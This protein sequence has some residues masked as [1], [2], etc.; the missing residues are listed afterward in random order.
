VF[1]FEG[2]DAAFEAVVDAFGDG[3]EGWW[4]EWD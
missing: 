3:F 4:L 1:V 2:V